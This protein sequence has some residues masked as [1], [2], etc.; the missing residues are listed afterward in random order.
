MEAQARR[1]ATL[2]RLT[3]A[4][5]LVAALLAALIYAGVSGLPAGVLGWLADGGQPAVTDPDIGPGGGPDAAPPTSEQEDPG[6]FLGAP[7]QPPRSYG[8]GPVRA[9]SGG[10]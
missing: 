6:E 8:G 10:S 5:A 9:R 2:K 1:A 7:Q 4:S 3:R